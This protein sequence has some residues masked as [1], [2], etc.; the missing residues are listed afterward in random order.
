MQAQTPYSIRNSFFPDMMC[1]A[2]PVYMWVFAIADFFIQVA[3]QG[4]T[5]WFIFY[6]RACRLGCNECDVVTVIC[7]LC[8]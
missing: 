7:A 1:T 6:L 5:S 4:V 3:R 2:G 8:A